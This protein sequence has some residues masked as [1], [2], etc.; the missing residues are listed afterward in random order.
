M[1]KIVSVITD[2]KLDMPGSRSMKQHSSI[3]H[4][5][6]PSD[7]LQPMAKRDG[8]SLETGGTRQDPNGK[9]SDK[10]Q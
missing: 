3:D 7:C 10:A 1:A 2:M 8:S 6:F 5:G 9:I 4:Q